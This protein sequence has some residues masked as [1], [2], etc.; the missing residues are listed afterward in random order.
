[1]GV[2]AGLK[3]KYSHDSTGLMALSLGSAMTLGYGAGKFYGKLSSILA[4]NSKS[5][6]MDMAYGSIRTGLTGIAA[7]LS[8]TV[9]ELTRGSITPTGIAQNWAVPFAMG[10]FSGMT[11]QGFS[12][13]VTGYN[14]Q[15]MTFATLRMFYLFVK[16]P[17]MGAVTS[18]TL[19]S[20][21][22]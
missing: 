8:D 13:S 14:A 4:N 9:I 5:V 12:N 19:N 1:M 15:F 6:I 18:D 16:P 10:A 7:G 11:Q 17:F 3:T 21:F 22:S 20:F 2:G